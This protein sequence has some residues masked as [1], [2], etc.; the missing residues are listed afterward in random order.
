MITNDKSLSSQI[1]WFSHG[2]RVS[3][4]LA[5]A[6]FL[7]NQ[8]IIGF[9]RCLPSWVQDI[10]VNRANEANSL[11]LKCSSMRYLKSVGNEQPPS[12]HDNQ[13]LSRNMVPAVI[14]LSS[15]KMKDGQK[16]STSNLFWTQYALNGCLNLI[17]E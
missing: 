13:E 5:K 15:W 17:L 16:K 12:T 4:L 14:R 7:H 2:S 9:A 1:S 3:D 10:R 8:T 6:F 11:S